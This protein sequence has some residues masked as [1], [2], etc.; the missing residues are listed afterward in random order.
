MELHIPDP[1]LVRLPV[2]EFGTSSGEL[3]FGR[4]KKRFAGLIRTNYSYEIDYTPKGTPLNRIEA[5]KKRK[6]RVNVP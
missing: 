3:S 6:R 2:Q 5:E 4:G 1:F